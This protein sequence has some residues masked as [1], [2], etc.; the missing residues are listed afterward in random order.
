MGSL[1][2]IFGPMFSGKTSELISE[3]KKFSK[4]SAKIICLKPKG[5]KEKI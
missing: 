5:K 4:T 2:V 3:H 1:T